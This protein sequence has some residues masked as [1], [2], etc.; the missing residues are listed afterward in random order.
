MAKKESREL[1]IPQIQLSQ[2]VVTIVG[3]TPLITNRFGEKKQ[4]AIEDKQT[5]EARVKKPP[6]D[7]QAEFEDAIYHLDGARGYGFPGSGIKK[8]LVAAGG[9]FADEKMTILRG[10]INITQP[11]IEILDSEPKM[12]RDPVRLKDGTA[13]LAYR[14]MF[15]NWRMKVPVVY[16]S[17]MIT[18]EQVL[19]LFQH[20]GFSVGIGD[21]RPEK[22]GVFGQFTIQ[23]AEV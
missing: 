21:W 15:E 13:S 4:E 17:N 7:P 22:N 11:L 20:A 16:N 1:S 2:M 8:A 9:R 23:G 12:R 3:T 14:P 18:K 6:R 19:N 5:K 10:I